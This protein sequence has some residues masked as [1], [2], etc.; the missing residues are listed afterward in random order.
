MQR[1]RFQ[2]AAIVALLVCSGGMP[3]ADAAAIFATGQRLVPGIPGVKDDTRENFIYRI[4][5]TSGTAVPVSPSTTGL[6]S[7]LGMTADGT[8]W[9]Y[10]SG[11]LG[12]VA[13][14]SGT[15]AGVAAGGPS[16]TA[17]DIAADG[18]KFIVAFNAANAT[19]QLHRFDPALSAWL[20][21]GSETAIGDAVD[22]A[23]GTP[24]GTARPF[25]I[26][27]GSVGGRAYGVDLDTYSLIGLDLGSGAAAVIGDIGAVRA[28][29][30]SGFTG[31]SAM[32]GVDTSGDGQFDSLF[33]AVNFWDHDGSPET[34]PF[35]F[36][37][38]ARFNLTDGTWDL[39][40]FNQGVIYFGMAS[41]PVPVPGAVW[42]LMSGI[43]T[44]VGFRRLN[45][46]R[47]ASPAA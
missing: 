5:V 45:R 32:T 27:L 39:V 16:A 12:T 31:F 44:L 3:V 47:S 14:D 35:R 30:R 11:S 37:G 8:L 2:G 15:F 33:G 13:I 23:R 34:P 4:D 43:G 19:Q 20:P 21:L 7:A 40:G 46:S 9:G 29:W 26:G 42:L 41:A 24:L 6:P 22:S 28:G 18:G 17:F 1:V 36:G 25:V 38:L 10:R